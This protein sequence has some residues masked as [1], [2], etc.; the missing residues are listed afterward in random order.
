FPFRYKKEYFQ[1][2]PKG[3]FVKALRAEG[4]PCSGGY[5]PLNTMPFLE[6][7]LKTKNFKKMYAKER[8]DYNR[9]LENNQCPENDRLCNEEAVWFTQSMLLGT[10]SDMDDIVIAIEKIHQNIG[11]IKTSVKS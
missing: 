3:E 4:I 7:A 11:K 8:L 1:D 9:Y 6:N 5:T 2:L 10:K